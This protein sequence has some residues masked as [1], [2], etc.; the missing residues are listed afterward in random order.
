[1]IEKMIQ[2][3]DAGRAASDI[4]DA[5]DFL[6]R[7]FGFLVRHRVLRVLKLCCVISGI[8]SIVQPVVIIGL[9]GSSFSLEM[10]QCHG[11]LVQSYV[12]SSDYSH[13]TFFTHRNS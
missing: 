10:F 2:P 9:S 8:P 7:D 4:N 3:V 13:P 11:K 12:F 5:V 1:M 6:F